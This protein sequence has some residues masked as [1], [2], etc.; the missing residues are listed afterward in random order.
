[1]EPQLAAQQQRGFFRL[2]LIMSVLDA[3]IFATQQAI[4]SLR[5]GAVAVTLSTPGSPP[6]TVT[7]S[8][9]NSLRSILVD[10]EAKRYNRQLRG[11]EPCR[12]T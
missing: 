8:D 11:L 6:Q 4:I 5:A 2:E 12:K 1:M 10:L 7:Y 9:L 3:T